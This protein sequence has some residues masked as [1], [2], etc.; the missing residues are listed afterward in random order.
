MVAVGSILSMLL[1]SVLCIF[2]STHVSS[3]RPNRLGMNDRPL[4]IAKVLIASLILSLGIKYLAP[5]LNIPSNEITALLAV[6]IPPV[7]LG[8]ALGWR[9]IRSHQ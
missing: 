9:E 5:L 2:S 4:F 3:N 1:L 7:A 6:F 8:L